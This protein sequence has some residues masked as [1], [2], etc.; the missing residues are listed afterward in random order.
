MKSSHSPASAIPL[1][2]DSIIANARDVLIDCAR[3]GEIRNTCRAVAQ[4]RNLDK[5]GFRDTLAAA[6]AT[7]QDLRHHE[8]VGILE[9]HKLVYADSKTQF[10]QSRGDLGKSLE[11]SQ[12]STVTGSD[13]PQT[14]RPPPLVLENIRVPSISREMSFGNQT[15]L[16][17]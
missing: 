5:F 1:H 13:R 6:I 4:L 7:A 10:R 9:L 17:L 2:N 15:T 3:R 8:V 14:R 11:V 16:S 12:S